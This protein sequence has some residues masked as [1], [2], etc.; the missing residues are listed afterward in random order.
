MASPVRPP[1]LSEAEAFF[2]PVIFL[3]GH[4]SNSQED[5]TSMAGFSSLAKK[6]RNSESA[7]PE[8]N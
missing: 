5:L 8:A 4:H 2:P 6:W 1:P 3:F 7:T